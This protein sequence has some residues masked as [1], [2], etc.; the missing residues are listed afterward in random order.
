MSALFLFFNLFLIGGKLLY[1]VV[2]I[3][4]IQQCKTLESP[5][6]CKEI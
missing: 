2:I 1:N 5:L 6:D 4:A 3:Y